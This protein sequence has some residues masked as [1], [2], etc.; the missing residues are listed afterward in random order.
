MAEVSKR[1]VWRSMQLTG[2]RMES[3]KLLTSLCSTVSTAVA[4]LFQITAQSK[5][6]DDSA[7]AAEL[8]A[9][10]FETSDLS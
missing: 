4:V 6:E 5:E 2:K 8:H 9:I 7:V 3:S 10:Y 1:T